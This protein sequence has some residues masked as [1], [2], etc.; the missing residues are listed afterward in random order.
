MYKVGVEMEIIARNGVAKSQIL[1]AIREAGIEIRNEGYTHRIMNT[2][3]A[4]S[5]GSLSA[6]G[7]ELVSPPMKGAKN[8]EKQ[9]TT[10]CE[11]IKDLTR[12]DR[13]CGIHVHFEVLDK[14]HFKRRVN[15]NS[16]VGK[17]RALKN[18]PAK[19]FTG[20]LLRNYGYFQPVIDS[21]VSPSRRGNSYCNYL[22]DGA[23]MTLEEIK[24]F[25]ENKGNYAHLIY[26][27]SGRYTVINLSSLEN[28]GTVEFRQMNGSTNAAKILNWI[29]IMERLVSRS[30]DR[31]Y[32]G[33]DCEDYN[34][35]IDG[36][37][38]F[39]GFG[40]NGVRNYSRNRARSNGFRA[41]S[42]PETQTTNNQSSER[43]TE[44][45]DSSNSISNIS[46][47]AEIRESLLV[48]ENNYN[49]YHRII[50]ATNQYIENQFGILR[51][52]NIVVDELIN[53]ELPTTVRNVD[54]IVE[55]FYQLRTEIEGGN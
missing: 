14:H 24:Q 48:L 36:F 30:W 33:R 16:S 23:K 49:S 17:L 22:P 44:T 46:E 8:I 25:S 38:D 1:A 43:A 39:L 4:V 10:I 18:K 42:G 9:I 53:H 3:K 21:L 40:N 12:I 37:M 13:T 31:K 7:F 50:D 26:G 45:G 51:L 54:A 34:L 52:R 19:K 28:Y 15:T 29:R 47:N 6:G 5:D 2:W 20:N 41:I 55:R 27:M 32:Q 11:A 35:T